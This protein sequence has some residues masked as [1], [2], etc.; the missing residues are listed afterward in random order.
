[1]ANRIRAIEDNGGGRTRNRQGGGR[2]EV[3]QNEDQVGIR[4]S[5]GRPGCSGQSDPQRKTGAFGDGGAVAADGSRTDLHRGKREIAG[6]HFNVSKAEA[7]DR[8]WVVN[9]VWI[10]KLI[11][12]KLEQIQGNNK[13]R[14]ELFRDSGLKALSF[15][16]RTGNARSTIHQE[17]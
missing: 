2:R 1:L 12:R 15:K 6:E 14:L 5:D 17:S 8:A 11:Q 10:L 9:D 4:D 13:W 7:S 3:G 16:G